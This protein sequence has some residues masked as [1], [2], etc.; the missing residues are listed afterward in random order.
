MSCQCGFNCQTISAF[1]MPG[2]RML[3]FARERF[4]CSAL[5]LRD[6][7]T[8]LNALFQ[9]KHSFKMVIQFIILW[10]SLKSVHTS[11]FKTFT[12]Q[13]VTSA[14]EGEGGYVFTPFCL[15]VCLSIWL[16]TGYLK[17]LYPGLGET[18]WTGWVCRKDKLIRFW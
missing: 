5:Q 10:T 16:C 2:L 7:Y 11:F 3:T 8:R 18:R 6:N 15:S 1:R 9:P 17:K 13:I 4:I 12:F 14:T